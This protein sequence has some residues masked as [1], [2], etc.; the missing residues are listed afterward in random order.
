[1]RRSQLRDNRGPSWPR[2]VVPTQKNAGSGHAASSSVAMSDST[3]VSLVSLP[4]A[5]LSAR[6]EPGGDV[7][8]MCG[9]AFTSMLAVVLFLAGMPLISMGVLAVTGVSTILLES[10]L[11]S[12]RRRL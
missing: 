10:A 9:C 12:R 1:M 4:A 6:V 8:L 7:A 3:A 11:A 2:W 5:A